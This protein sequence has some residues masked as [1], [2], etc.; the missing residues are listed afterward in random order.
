MTTKLTVAAA[1]G[2]C[3]CKSEIYMTTKLTV[4]T[5]NEKMRVAFCKLFFQRNKQRKMKKRFYDLRLEAEN[6][7]RGGGE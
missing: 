4:A 7:P 3:G 2:K 6:T 1:S 5:A